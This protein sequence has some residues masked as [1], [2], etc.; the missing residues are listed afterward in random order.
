MTLKENE[1]DVNLERMK[2]DES[3]RINRY[4]ATLKKT[5]LGKPKYRL[6]WSEDMFELRSKDRGEKVTWLKKYS[7]IRNR[8]L[9]ECWYP[10]EVYQNEELPTTM[11]GKGYYEVFYVFEKGNEALP[12]RLD[13]VEI[14]MS[15]ILN[16]SPRTIV[17][18]IKEIEAQMAAEE[19]RLDDYT[20]DMLNEDSTLTGALHDGDAV[21]IQGDNQFGEMVEASKAVEDKNVDN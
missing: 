10:P 21:F 3:E 8:W 17:Q 7:Y 6:V 2:T 20:M 16:Q 13:V 19:K 18:R 9:L 1:T 4:L 15:A 12:L 5:P 11:L 14:L